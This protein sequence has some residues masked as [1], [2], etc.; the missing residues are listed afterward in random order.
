VTADPSVPTDEELSELAVAVV[1]AC[2]ARGL[3]LATAESCT[4]GLIGHLI[5]EVPGASSCF[6]G[7]VISYS[8][9]LKEALLGVPRD[10]LAAHGAVS[11]TVAVAMADGARMRTGADIAV[12]VTGVAGPDG[13]TAAKPVGL[14]FIACASAT[15]TVVHERRWLG[16]RHANKRASAGEALALALA[17]ADATGARGA[18]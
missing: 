13:G 3:T 7:G 10:V 11:E 12:A 17:A 1:R 2:A 14:A 5:T 18:Y 4:G 9:A 15:G 6:V 16:D 8:N